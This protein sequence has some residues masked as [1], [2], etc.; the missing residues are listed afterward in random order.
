MTFDE[1]VQAFGTGEK[2]E[3]A[4]EMAERVTVTL[5]GEPLL[6]GPTS[7]LSNRVLL[8][9]RSADDDAAYQTA[10]QSARTVAVNGGRG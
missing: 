5:G 8:T 3:I 4:L 9:S 7:L 2:T 10:Y 6:M 1:V